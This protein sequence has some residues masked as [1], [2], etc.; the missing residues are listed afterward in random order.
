MVRDQTDINIERD[1]GV[2]HPERINFTNP[3]NSIQK[4]FS[5]ESLAAGGEGDRLVDSRG[6][7]DRGG[8]ELCEQLAEHRNLVKN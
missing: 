4:S 3:F 1:P 5:T 7:D 6:F 2:T 8:T